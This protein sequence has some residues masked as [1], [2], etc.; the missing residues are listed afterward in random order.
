MVRRGLEG[1]AVKG[2]QYGGRPL[3]PVDGSDVLSDPLVRA[4]AAK[5]IATQERARRNLFRMHL[6]ASVTTMNRLAFEFASAAGDDAAA[7][8]RQLR[9][10]A[11]WPWLAMGSRP[12][13]TWWIAAEALDHG[14][15]AD[16]ARY[17][18]SKTVAK[19][20]VAQ[21]RQSDDLR[22][23]A[24]GACLEV[25]G[26]LGRGHLVTRGDIASLEILDDLPFTIIASMPGRT[27]GELIDHPLFN[28]RDYV[29]QS[30]ER[31]HW[32]TVLVTFYTGRVPVVL[33][34]GR[35]LREGGRG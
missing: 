2:R 9:P 6:Q 32:G 4:A 5:F 27:M 19:G 17:Y 8:A 11:G 21:L 29:I 28:G 26:R 16:T 23:R 31:A 7:V 20:S 14:F 18:G 33:P 3:R 22:Y 13:S 12:A 10:A 30:A 25:D 24:I 35:L 1:F 15:A 34:W